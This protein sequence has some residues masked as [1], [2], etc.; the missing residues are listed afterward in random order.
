M[1]AALL[2][3][4]STHACPNKLVLTWIQTKCPLSLLARSPASRTGSA[5]GLGS[6][7]SARWPC[8]AAKRDTAALLLPQ[9]ASSTVPV[10]AGWAAPPAACSAA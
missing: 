3:E 8:A 6:K 2:T 9:P 10:P 1:C 7:H 5:S 4:F